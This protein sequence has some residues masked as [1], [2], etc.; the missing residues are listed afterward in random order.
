MPSRSALSALFPASS[1]CNS[2]GR[3]VPQ[4]VPGSLA[5]GNEQREEAAAMRK[6]MLAAFL[7]FAYLRP[8]AESAAELKQETSEAFDHYI[9]VTEDRVAEELHEA[10]L[11]SLHRPLGRSRMRVIPW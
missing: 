10:S 3:K 6:V 2:V 11:S 5:I 1:A 9:R 7:A 8:M 4:R